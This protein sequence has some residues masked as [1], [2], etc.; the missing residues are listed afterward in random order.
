ME[1][2][3]FTSHLKQGKSLARNRSKYE[4]QV[5]AI[6]VIKCRAHARLRRR[7]PVIAA[8]GYLADESKTRPAGDITIPILR[9]DDVIARAK[10]RR[11]SIQFNEACRLHVILKSPI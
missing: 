2:L 9:H 4:R 7:N 8:Y 6:G 10:L 11:L 1:Y 3:R 5:I